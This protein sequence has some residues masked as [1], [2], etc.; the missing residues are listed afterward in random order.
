MQVLKKIALRSRVDII[1]FF[2]EILA[3]KNKLDDVH[4]ELDF[5]FCFYVDCNG[6]SKGLR[7]LWKKIV[8]VTI[9]DFTTNCIDSYV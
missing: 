5:D 4:R 1:I 9:S 3:N 2:S 7:L 8:N 6:R